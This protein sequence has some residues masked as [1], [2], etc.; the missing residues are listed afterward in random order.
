MKIPEIDRQFFTEIYDRNRAMMSFDKILNLYYLIINVLEKKIEGQFI[1]AGCYKGY[2]AILIQKM[3]TSFNTTKQLVVFDSFQGLPEKSNQDFLDANKIVN[4][5]ILQDNKRINK[6]WFSSSKQILIDNFKKYKLPLPKIIEGWFEDTLM[7]NL[8]DKIAFAHLDGDLYSS[9]KVALENIFP[10]MIVGGILL[11]DDYCDKK[12]SEN[13]LPGV[14]IACDEYFKNKKSKVKALP[15]LSSS[16]QA[17][18]IKEN[19]KLV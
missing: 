8:P 6:G 15:T 3:L 12:L 5:K 13:P 10:K 7:N 18:V 19:E 2:S 11:I 16:H 9:T 14:R 1:E 4:K 17:L